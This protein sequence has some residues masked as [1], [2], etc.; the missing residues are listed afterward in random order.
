MRPAL[1]L[2]LPEPEWVALLRAE[3]AKG[4]SISQIARETGMARPS[5]SMLLSGKY[6]AQ[7]LDLATRKHGARIV[8]LYRN[9]VLC[10]HLR[11]GISAETCATYARAPM[12]T[13]NPEKLR[14]WQACR[15]CLLN[16]EGA[17]K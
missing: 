13:S 3:Q 4:K 12:S 8:H 10:P 2:D 14:H 9:Q 7:S 11:T 16:P 17:S 1:N 15:R 6:P 5:V